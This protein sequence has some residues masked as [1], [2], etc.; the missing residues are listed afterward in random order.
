MPGGRVEVSEDSS[1]GGYINDGALNRISDAC[2]SW[3]IF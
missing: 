2:F 1:C 3:W